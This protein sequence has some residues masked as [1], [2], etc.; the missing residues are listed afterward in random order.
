MRILS[1]TR[2]PPAASSL[3][4]ASRNLRALL[5]GDTARLAACVEEPGAGW[6]ALCAAV[7]VLGDGVYGCTLGWW[8]GPLQ[9][10][11]TAVKFPLL[12]FLTCGGN[13]L[14]NGLL[15]AVL[16]LGLSLRQSMLTILMSFTLTA[17]ILG[18]F[19]PVM[20]FLLGN[21]PP[22]TAH[23]PASHSVLLTAH[24]AVIAFAGVVANRRLL[25][26]LERLAGRASSAR[27]ILFAW[28]TG[29]LL[30]GSQLAWVLRP[31]VGS[32]GLPVQ[33]LRDD[34]LRGNFFE[35]VFHA[36]KHLFR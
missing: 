36:C 34:P 9:S 24:V 11:Y 21:T 5:T 33:F 10:L 14:L 18:A 3:A 4:L 30:L 25:G 19:S 7:I 31:F 23:Q 29:N 26:L 35:A 12:V 20:L 22:L 1:A 15:A 2:T 28:L 16:G 13:A 17:L 32:P 8:R 6:L 27:A